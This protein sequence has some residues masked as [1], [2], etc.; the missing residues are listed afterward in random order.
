MTLITLTAAGLYCPRGDFYI[1][2]W[3]PVARA[4]ITHAHA[5]HA[6]WGSQAY[7]TTTEGVGVLRARVGPDAVIRGL[8]YG[9]RL[10]IGDVDVSLH[11]AGHILGSAQVR[12]AAAGDVWVISGDYKTDADPT[13][14]PFEPV[15]C[16]TFVTEATFALPIYRWRPQ[17]EIFAT[18]NAWWRANQNAGQASLLLGYALG[19]AQRLIAGLD[20]QIGPIVCHGAVERMNEHYRAAGVP[21]PPTRYSGDVPQGFDWSRAIIIA[22]PGAHGTS[23]TR[24]FGAFSAGFA[25]GWMQIRGARRRRAVD[26]G[27]ALSDHADWPGLLATIAATGAER[28]W[29]TH[30]YSAVL[31]RWL[32]EHGRE[33]HTVPTRFEG[34]P[35]TD[36]QEQL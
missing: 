19:K 11:P 33:A 5:D 9:E 2:P 16:R 21:L 20:P 34:E 6:R 31:A 1:D 35:T 30:G 4:V 7:L 32:T 24:R 25:S 23:W 12:V 27:F 13:C 28:I 15:R 14:T 18:I 26:Q 3:Q 29:V 10:R 22:P 8:T 36:D 17:A